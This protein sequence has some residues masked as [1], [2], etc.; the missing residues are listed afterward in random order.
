MFHKFLQLMIPP[1]MREK[2]AT[3]RMEEGVVED[4]DCFAPVQHGQDRGGELNFTKLSSC[5][6]PDWGALV[7]FTGEWQF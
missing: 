7:I 1:E 2:T 4:F 5:D 3:R 6:T